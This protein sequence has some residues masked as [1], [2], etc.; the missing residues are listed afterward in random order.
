MLFNPNIILVGFM[1]S[2]KT[3][4]GKEISKILGL[5]FWDMDKWI[6]KKNKEKII[7]IFQK[8]GESFFRQQERKAVLWLSR[9]KNY[10]VSTGGGT[11]LQK[12][13][14]E[15]LLESGWCVWLKVSAGD[16]WKRVGAHLEKRPLLSRSK[17][18][19]QKIRSLL[20]ERNPHYALAH[21]SVDTTEKN[22]RQ[23]AVEVVKVFK[24]MK[25]FDPSRF[26]N[27][28]W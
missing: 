8:K 17:D 25:P 26:K 4:T 15:K 11:W 13:N 18:P 5:R 1:G 2:G 19:K 27:I 10:V 6:E 14:R 23:V 24:K 9:Q 22:P 28:C 12:K 16:V 21:A 20:S 7:K 3:S